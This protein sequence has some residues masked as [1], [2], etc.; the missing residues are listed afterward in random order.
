M[1]TTKNEYIPSPEY[2]KTYTTYKEHPDIFRP[3]NKVPV[4]RIKLDRKRLAFPNPVRGKDVDY[5]INNFCLEGWEPIMIDT[6]YF[7]VDGQHR[8]EAAK[9][10]GLKYIDVIIEDTEKL[11]AK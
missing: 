3:K 10:M 6:H 8:L 11:N 9:R 1:K 5:L 2:F 4:N 7:L